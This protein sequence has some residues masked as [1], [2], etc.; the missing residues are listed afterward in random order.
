MTYNTLVFG[1][2]VEA[3]VFFV[4]VGIFGCG[5]LG[6]PWGPVGGGDGDGE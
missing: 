2:F 6:L 1:H 4:R 3:D 5:D